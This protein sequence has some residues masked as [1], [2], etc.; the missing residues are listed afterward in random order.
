[1]HF[2]A[3][4]PERTIAQP[5]LPVRYSKHMV[6]FNLKTKYLPYLLPELHATLRH[7]QNYSFGSPKILETTVLTGSNVNGEG[8]NGR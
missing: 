4:L 6:S 5:C 1:M 2:L 8:R 7:F 3:H